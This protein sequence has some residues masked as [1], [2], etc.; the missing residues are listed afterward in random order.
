MNALVASDKVGAHVALWIVRQEASSI[1]IVQSNDIVEIEKLLG[2]N[3]RVRN[4]RMAFLVHPVQIRQALADLGGY[5]E[6][7]ICSNVCEKH[8]WNV[9]LK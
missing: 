3:I 1:E 5:I 8:N 2:A 9:M 4:R 6:E 7:F